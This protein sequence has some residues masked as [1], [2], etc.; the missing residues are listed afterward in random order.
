MKLIPLQILV[1]LL[2]NRVV[3][4]LTEHKMVAIIRWSPEGI[5]LHFA[6]HR[7]NK[8]LGHLDM[9]TPSAFGNSDKEKLH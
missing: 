9:P 7:C 2:A 8:D 3:C 1:P 4:K 6:C 5:C